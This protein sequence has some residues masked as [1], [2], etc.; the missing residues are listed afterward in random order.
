MITRRTINRL[1]ARIEDNECDIKRLQNKVKELGKVNF[2]RENVPKFK[3]FDIV[4]T[5]GVSQMVPDLRA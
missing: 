3:P 4:L 2:E 1:E 5:G